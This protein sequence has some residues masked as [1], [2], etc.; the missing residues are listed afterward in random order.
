MDAIT[1]M[2]LVLAVMIL[3]SSDLA[4]AEMAEIIDLN[5]QKQLRA[6]EARC[7]QLIDLNCRSSWS[8][9]FV[10]TNFIVGRCTAS[11]IASAS[12]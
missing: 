6:I 11:A 7:R 2:L 10:A 12:R 3:I 8:A 9:V 5:R 1:I 4:E